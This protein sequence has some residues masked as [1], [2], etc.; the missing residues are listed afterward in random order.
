MGLTE[1]LW[2]P[3]AFYKQIKE[4]FRQSWH[5]LGCIAIPPRTWEACAKPR[6]PL[7]PPSAPQLWRTSRRKMLQLW[8]KS[9]KVPST[10]SRIHSERLWWFCF[11]ELNFWFHMCCHGQGLPKQVATAMKVVSGPCCLSCEAPK[12]E[13]KLWWT[14]PSF[15]HSEHV[16]S[17]DF[18]E[19]A[20]PR[21]TPE[22][23][24][25]VYQQSRLPPTRTSIWA[26]HSA[27][28]RRGTVSCAW[29]SALSSARR[30]IC[31]THLIAMASNLR[32][33]LNQLRL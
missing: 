2:K 4:Y 5:P 6:L 31:N 1:S 17:L 18:S 22:H 33:E 7:R 14:H 20:D 29:S 24:Q 12:C 19:M 32:Q 26:P 3:F 8:Y 16:E 10:I 13:N 15:F 28:E 21:H 27:R 25:E 9:L 23:P 30:N 11:W